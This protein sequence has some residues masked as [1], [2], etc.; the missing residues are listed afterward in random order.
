MIIV[1]I[2]ISL[3]HFSAQAWSIKKFYY[4]RTSYIFS[5]EKGFLIFR[6]LELSSHKL[7]NLLYFF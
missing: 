7:K 4:K 2:D 6:E 3:A 1:I 5:N